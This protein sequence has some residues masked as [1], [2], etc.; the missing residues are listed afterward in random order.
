MRKELGRGTP[1]VKRALEL[2][3][4]QVYAESLEEF[5]V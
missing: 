5:N 4:C 2:L 1:A 3:M